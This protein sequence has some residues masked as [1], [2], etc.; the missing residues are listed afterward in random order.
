MAA[1][2]CQCRVTSSVAGG[3]RAG[4]GQGRG[5]A[6]AIALLGCEAGSGW[7]R[8]TYSDA[9]GA[10]G[11]RTLFLF[12]SQTIPFRGRGAHWPRWAS[13]GWTA[14]PELPVT[15]KTQPGGT[16]RERDASS[17]VPSSFVTKPVVSKERTHQTENTEAPKIEATVEPTLLEDGRRLRARARPLP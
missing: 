2:H 1:H 7:V 9:N 8:A 11:S 10:A 16:T 3:A 5:G 15:L 12:P 17:A 13:S 6:G 14:C 4:T